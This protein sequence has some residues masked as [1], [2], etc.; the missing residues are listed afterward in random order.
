MAILF[1]RIPS[2]PML[3]SV[4]FDEI[5]CN[6]EALKHGLTTPAFVASRYKPVS[7]TYSICKRG[8]ELDQ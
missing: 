2:R 5:S 1:S 3:S 8:D 6:D 7:V 4:I